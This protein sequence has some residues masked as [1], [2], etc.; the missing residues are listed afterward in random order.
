MASHIERLADYHDRGNWRHQRE[1]APAVL[2][3]G[4]GSVAVI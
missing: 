1:R 3:T 2:A 4:V